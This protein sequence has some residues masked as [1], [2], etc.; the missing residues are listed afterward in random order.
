MKHYSCIQEAFFKQHLYEERIGYDHNYIYTNKTWLPQLGIEPKVSESAYRR[1]DLWATE[2]RLGPLAEKKKPTGNS[3]V[4]VTTDAL[5]DVSCFFWGFY[6]NEFKVFASSIHAEFLLAAV[7]S[8]H[9]LLKVALFHSIS[10]CLFQ[11]HAATDSKY[12]LY[13][14]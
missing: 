3:G 7:F 1:S 6:L 12:V 4:Y 5:H 2:T 8:R 11:S 13:W 10:R 14:I 9:P